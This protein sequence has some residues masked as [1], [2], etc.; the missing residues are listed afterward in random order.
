MDLTPEKA[1]E[2]LGQAKLFNLLATLLVV[3][4]G[5]FISRKIN[6]THKTSQRFVFHAFV[7]WW[8]SW[9]VLLLSWL[10][11]KPFPDLNPVLQTWVQLVTSDVNSL[12]LILG[13]IVLMHAGKSY[14]VVDMLFSG[15]GFVLVLG[16]TYAGLYGFMKSA[17]G[18]A[19]A[20]HQNV[21]LCLAAA[22]PVLFAWALWQVY[23][24]YLPLIAGIIYGL[25]QPVAFMALFGGDVTDTLAAKEKLAISLLFLGV[26]KIV[27]AIA[28]ARVF[29]EKTSS[30]GSIN[31]VRGAPQE[32]A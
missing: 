30:A 10:A 8:L 3:A 27:W 19:S 11:I 5:A 20:V 32:F 1:N 31:L 18:L 7:I 15:V 14:N 16:V 28:V 9:L 12:L 2:L 29:F 4:G 13:A 23:D 22:G 17:D 25:A 24:T 6:S 26:M 21:V